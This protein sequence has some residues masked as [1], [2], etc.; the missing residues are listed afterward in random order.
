M[1]K[2]KI[3]Q[4][5]KEM[6]YSERKEKAEVLLSGEYNKLRFV[7]LNLG[8]HPTAYV[9]C[10]VDYMNH[11]CVDLKRDRLRDIH[12]H[13]G[14]T[15]FGKAYWNNNDK[16]R[17]LGWSYDHFGDYTSIDPEGKK[18]TTEEIH[19]DVKNVIDQLRREMRMHNLKQGV[20]WSIIGG[21]IVTGVDLIYNTIK[22]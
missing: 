22:D 17:Y 9:E 8:T 16:N 4:E 20:K 2:E 15:Y 3:T 1:A 21:L 12:A 6:I 14:L 19:Q 18:Y 13:G 7:I 10:H 11:G 5:A